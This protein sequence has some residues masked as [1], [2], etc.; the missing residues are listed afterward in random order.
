MDTLII[1][2]VNAAGWGQ[3]I[4]NAAVTGIVPSA[5]E[6]AFPDNYSGNSADAYFFT[7]LDTGLDTGG[8]YRIA[9]AAAPL[10]ST[11]KVLNLGTGD[12]P[13]GIDVNSLDCSGNTIMAGLARYARVFVSDDL[14]LHWSQS[15]KPPSGQTATCVIIAPDFANQHK[16]YAVTSGAES[17][18]SSS[19]DGGKTWDQTGL[20]DTSVDAITDINAP[21][22]TTAFVLTFNTVNMIK[23]LW[24]T[25]DGGAS[26]ERIFCG[27]YTGVTDYPW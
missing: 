22:Q 11:V 7:D 23:S 2:R 25:L 10:A 14:G 1:N 6:I 24:R 5:G 4:G 21:T 12:T 18:F 9:S 20:I 16:A 17:A 15:T 13:V 19:S 3:T 27:S 8:I 26:W